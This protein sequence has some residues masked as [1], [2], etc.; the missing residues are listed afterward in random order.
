MIASRTLPA[1]YSQWN[2]HWGAPGGRQL[3]AVVNHWRF[4]RW[5]M[6]YRGPFAHQS[7]SATRAFEYPW[8]HD[9]VSRRGSELDIIEVGG[10]LSG[11]QFVLG[12]EGHRVTNVDPGAQPGAE[13]GFTPDAHK[14]LCQLFGASVSLIPN[15]IEHAELGDQSADVLMSV[16]VLEHLE[17][18]AL[19]ATASQI[20][21]ILRPS[22]IAIL[23][24]DLFVD[25]YPFTDR[26][27]GDWGRNVNVRDF[28]EAAGLMLV[29]GDRSEL[30]GFPEFNAQDIDARRDSYLLSDVS[31]TAQCLIAK[32]GHA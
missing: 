20:K 12:R 15:S 14:Y 25:L 3:P 7:N 5:A 18:S 9:A 21:R 8:A 29:S 2:R 11:M 26:R 19:A 32:L 22:G 30:F 23:T 27:A 1:N 6:Q 16:S 13:W 4:Q 28:L 31:S 24:I 10:G 17:P